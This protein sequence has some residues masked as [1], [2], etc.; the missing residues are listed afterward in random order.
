MFSSWLDVSIL[1]LQLESLQRQFDALTARQHDLSQ[2]AAITIASANTNYGGAESETLAD[3]GVVGARL[4]AATQ[5]C[6]EMEDRIDEL[7][8]ESSGW[9]NGIPS[10]CGG[11]VCGGVGHKNR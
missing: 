8:G 2:A 11:G 10:Y 5:R 4:A 9:H 6:A 7:E 3:G 1:C